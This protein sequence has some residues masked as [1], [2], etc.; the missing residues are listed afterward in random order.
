MAQ[1]TAFPTNVV[2]AT[3]KKQS[4]LWLCWLIHEHRHNL[5][6]SLLEKS[7]L[8]Q[9]AYEEGH[10]VGYDKARILGNE[11]NSRY[12]KYM[13]LAYMACLTNPTSQPSFDTSPIC[14][15]INSDEV[16]GSQ[17]SV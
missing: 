4:D 12:K 10:R 5:K 15:P 1:H 13:E 17:R 16:P 8:A 9:H 7:K 11:H 2:E 6:E 14:I 3:M